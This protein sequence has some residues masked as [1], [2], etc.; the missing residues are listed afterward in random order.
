[1][2]T[3][4][5][6]LMGITVTRDSIKLIHLLAWNLLLKSIYEDSTAKLKWFQFS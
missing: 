4:K 2:Y 1:M 5:Q 3:S 6:H